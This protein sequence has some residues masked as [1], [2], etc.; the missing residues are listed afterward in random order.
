LSDQSANKADLAHQNMITGL[1]FG[2]LALYSA[3]LTFASGSMLGLT[4]ERLTNRLRSLIF[5]VSN[6]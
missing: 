4:G 1:L 6:F 2:A 5:K 3:L